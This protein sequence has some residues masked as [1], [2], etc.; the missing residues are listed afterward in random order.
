MELTRTFLLMLISLRL[1]SYRRL[2]RWC[3]IRW[4]G[5]AFTTSHGSYPY[6]ESNCS[7]HSYKRQFPLLLTLYLLTAFIG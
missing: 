3:V 2:L 4:Y 7:R 6:T 5:E 1:V